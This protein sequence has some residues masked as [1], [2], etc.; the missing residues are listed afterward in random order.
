MLLLSA[1]IVYDKGFLM[2]I[3]RVSK[4]R[5]QTWYLTAALASMTAEASL[6]VSLTLE[7]VSEIRSRISSGVR[8]A[9]IRVVCPA[10]SKGTIMKGSA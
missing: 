2:L 8:A 9:E 7:E 1:R 3:R 6:I 4:V 5:E 10:R